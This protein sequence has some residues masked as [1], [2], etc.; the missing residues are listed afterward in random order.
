MSDK[1]KK[2]NC[3]PVKTADELAEDSRVLMQV[4]DKLIGDDKLIPSLMP[5]ADKKRD[6]DND[7]VY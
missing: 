4:D 5:E 3:D 2:E 1:E 7:P 6:T